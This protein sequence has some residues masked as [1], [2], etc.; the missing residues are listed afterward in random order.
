MSTPG[1]WKHEDKETM[2][3]LIVDGFPIKFTSDENENLLIQVLK[4]K[5]KTTIDWEA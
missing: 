4:D 2:L 5:Y 3:S 1:L